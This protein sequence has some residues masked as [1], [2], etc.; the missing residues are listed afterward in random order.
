MMEMISK[1]T[2]VNMLINYMNGTLPLA[3]LV[4][5]AETAL[6]DAPVDTAM[7]HD[8]LA[9]L[10]AGDVDGFPLGWSECHNFLT[11]LGATVHVEAVAI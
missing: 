4:A 5:W 2:V 8:V 1:Q 11:Q 7:T 10:G 3:D 6:I 9:Y